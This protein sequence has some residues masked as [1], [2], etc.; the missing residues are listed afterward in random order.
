MGI[1]CRHK[2]LWLIKLSYK[3]YSKENCDNDTEILIVIDLDSFQ[4]IPFKACFYN[5]L[6]SYIY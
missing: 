1:L 3:I 2:C 6:F 5:S 4:K